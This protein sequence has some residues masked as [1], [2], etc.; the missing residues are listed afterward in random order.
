M[1]NK[2]KMSTAKGGKMKGE[3]GK[4]SAKKDANTKKRTPFNANNDAK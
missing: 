4:G 3:S 1:A 2:G